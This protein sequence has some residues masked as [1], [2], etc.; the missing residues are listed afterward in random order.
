MEKYKN[1][2]APKEDKALYELHE[3]RHALRIVFRNKTVEQ[4][5]R[6]AMEKYST[7]KKRAIKAY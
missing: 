2:Y 4:I 3:I 7:L 6:E 5:N 1:D